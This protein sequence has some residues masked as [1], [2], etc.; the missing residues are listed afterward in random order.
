LLPFA[1]TSFQLQDNTDDATEVSP[2]LPTSILAP[3]G[4]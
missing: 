3:I 2:P 1:A 4:W